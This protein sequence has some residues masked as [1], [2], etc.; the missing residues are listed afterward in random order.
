MATIQ[1]TEARLLTAPKIEGFAIQQWLPGKNPLDARYWAAAKSN[2]TIG[3]WLS[4]GWISVDLSEDLP[5]PKTPP[6]APELAEFSA[7]E[8]SAALSNPSVPV[9]WH[10]ALEGEIDRRRAVEV[11]KNLPP[12][13]PAKKERKSLSGIRVEDALPLIAAEQD[14]ETLEAW[15]DAD[16]RK[17]IDEAIDERLTTLAL[18]EDE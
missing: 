8:L 1:N 16:K 18:G 14:P 2:R 17:A 13:T 6:S 3:R 7:Q 10:S 12:A 4:L 15:A 11:Q 9:Q 5:D